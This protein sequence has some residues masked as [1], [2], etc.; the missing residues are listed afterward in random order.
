MAIRQ[1][2]RDTT[3]SSWETT[4]NSVGTKHPDEKTFNKHI[5]DIYANDMTI[6][7]ATYEN[8]LLTLFLCKLNVPSPHLKLTLAKISIPLFLM[9]GRRS[10]PF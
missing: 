5:T 4:M 6:H 7:F 9:N 8:F 2:M 1:S 10:M 3:N